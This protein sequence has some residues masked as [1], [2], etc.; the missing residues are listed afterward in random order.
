[1][2]FSDKKAKSE[3]LWNFLLY[4]SKQHILRD[5]YNQELN[6]IE[7]LSP[8]QKKIVLDQNLEQR[9]KDGL[10]RKIEI[11]PEVDR[12]EE[13]LRDDIEKMLLGVISDDSIRDG[14]ELL[15]E[16]IAKVYVEYGKEAER[17]KSRFG[18][19][20]N[21]DEK[22]ILV[23]AKCQNLA[24]TL[25]EQVNTIKTGMLSYLVLYLD[26][27][28]KIASYMASIESATNAAREKMSDEDKK[29]F[30]IGSK[31]KNGF[32]LSDDLKKY[33]EVN[34][35]ADKL[36]KA[37]EHD[38]IVRAYGELRDAMTPRW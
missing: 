5:Q 19:V 15:G 38:N 18:N 13:Y 12:M 30:D 27:E 16:M 36:A 11:S 2:P 4:S 10:P 20:K 21:R 6:Q 25:D 34:G 9:I 29:L 3:R 37:Y 26:D 32:E 22:A 17:V 35:P 23:T 24:S 8:E 28:D 31:V 14:F 1:M 7:K 33:N